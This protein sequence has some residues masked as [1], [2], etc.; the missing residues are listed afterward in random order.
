MSDE[1][2]GQVA[3]E[4]HAIR[5]QL[6]NVDLLRA[7]LQSRVRVLEVSDAA[8]WRELRKL[9]NKIDSRFDRLD[10]LV[11]ANRT[12]GAVMDSKGKFTAW[13]IGIVLTLILVLTSVVNGVLSFV[14]RL[15]S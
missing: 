5:E 2:I 10:E 14:E 3:Q 9:E 4:L 8:A 11:S 12:A 15:S 1:T 7:E 13:V 6:H